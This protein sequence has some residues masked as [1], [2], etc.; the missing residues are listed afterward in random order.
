MHKLLEDAFI[1]NASTDNLALFFI[2]RDVYDVIWSLLKYLSLLFRNM[3]L[4]KPVAIFKAD[5]C[6]QL[7]LE[8]SLIDK[9]TDSS[10]MHEDDEENETKSGDPFS[11][12]TL[13]ERLVFK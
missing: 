2:K 10:T 6:V 8:P 13:R 9:L 4:L 3:F 5:E 7:D 12:E 11:R 1:K